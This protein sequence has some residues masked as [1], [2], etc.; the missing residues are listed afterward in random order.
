MRE[1]DAAEMMARIVKLQYKLQVKLQPSYETTYKTSERQATDKLN[2]SQRQSGQALIMSDSAKR[3][4]L[5]VPIV[6]A[7]SRTT[8]KL[9]RRYASLPQI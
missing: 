4:S 3:H 6:P 5:I 2:T 8:P 1:E 9:V 7:L